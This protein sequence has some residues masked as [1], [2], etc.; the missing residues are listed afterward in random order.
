MGD[1]ELPRAA[2]SQRS[3]APPLSFSVYSVPKN[4]TSYRARNAHTR[5]RTLCYYCIHLNLA[6]LCM[7]TLCLAKLAS[8]RAERSRLMLPLRQSRRPSSRA[9]RSAR[10][11]HLL[12]TGPCASTVQ[13]TVQHVRSGQSRAEQS[14][15]GERV[16]AVMSVQV[17]CCMALCAAACCLDQEAVGRSTQGS[18]I[19]RAAAAATGPC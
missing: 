15:A 10:T 4:H 9:L 17:G 13:C 16:D 7:V 1:S 19:H 2:P 12:R 3:P 5:C 11:Q 14:M 6:L 8:R 18:V